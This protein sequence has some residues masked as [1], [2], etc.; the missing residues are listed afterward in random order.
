MTPKKM[1]EQIRYSADAAICIVQD[2]DGAF[3]CADQQDMDTLPVGDD[4]TAE[5]IDL[6]DS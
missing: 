5:E 6:L 3:R 2:E 1:K 4:L